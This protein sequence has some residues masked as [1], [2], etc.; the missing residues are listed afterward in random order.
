MHL[1][2]SS[3][4]KLD[5]LEIPVLAK[6]KLFKSIYMLEGV[7]FGFRMNAKCPHATGDD[8]TSRIDHEPGHRHGDRRRHPHLG[9]VCD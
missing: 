6:L 4:L 1:T 3:D 9:R 7:A 5:Y 2:S 8:Q